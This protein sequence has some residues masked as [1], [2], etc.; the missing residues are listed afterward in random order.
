MRLA[1]LSPL[2]LLAALSACGGDR[3]PGEDGTEISIKGTGGNFTAGVGKDGAIAIDAPG[4]KGSIALPKINLDAG[5]FDINGVKLPD[6]SKVESLNIDGNNGDGG[7]K[8]RFT[9]PV[10][11]AAVRDWFQGK[12]AAEGF[13]LQASGDNLTGTTDEGK[14]FSLTTTPSGTGRSESEIVIR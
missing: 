13:K 1:M 10:G 14:A 9:S 7:V 3:A 12:L 6:G 8:V 4:F 5:D 2:P 11:T